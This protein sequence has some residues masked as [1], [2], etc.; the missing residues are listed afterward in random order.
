MVV[1]GSGFGQAEGTFHFRTTFLPS[2]GDIGHV[3]EALGA[4][5][6]DFLQRYGGLGQQQQQVEAVAANGSH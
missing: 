4:F 5:H 6:A 3:V 2:E 1:P